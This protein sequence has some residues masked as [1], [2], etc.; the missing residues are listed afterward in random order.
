MWG[1]GLRAASVA[2]T[3]AG[4]GHAMPKPTRRMRQNATTGCRGA[5]LSAACTAPSSTAAMRSRRMEGL[6]SRT[7]SG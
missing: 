3:E 1:S 7:S 5:A 2:S 4:G 6:L